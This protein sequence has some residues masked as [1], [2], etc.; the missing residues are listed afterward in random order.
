MPLT[1]KRLATGHEARAIIER[2]LSVALK[3][4]GFI[5]Q[6][7]LMRNSP[8]KTGTLRRSWSVGEP[9]WEG[10]RFIVKVGTALIYA[11]IVNARG[12]SKEYIDRS[13]EQARSQL[14]EAIHDALHK[15]IQQLKVA[16]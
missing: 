2:E 5:L 11:R 14:K 10:D 15:A 12:K 3:R 8:V 6:G 4:A 7:F 13:I 16:L 1:G 9:R